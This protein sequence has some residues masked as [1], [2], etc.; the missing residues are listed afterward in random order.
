MTGPSATARRS[1]DPAWTGSQG[2]DVRVP[3]VARIY[4]YLLG[5][6]DN[7]A[8]DRAA[9][10]ELLAAVPDAAVA[11]RANRRFLGRAVWHLARDAG[12]RQFLDIG[13]G[14]PT[15]G[16]VHE[17]AR[18]AGQDARVV[19]CDNDPLVAVHASVAAVHGN[20]RQPRQLLARPA[21][22]AQLNL[23]EPVVVLLVACCTSSRTARTPGRSWRRSSSN[24]HPAVSGDL[25]RHRG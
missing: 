3:N 22:R 9:A 24:W 14:L 18:P 15:R 16:N 1:A 13:T 6:K 11:A 17:I 7:F 19:Y 5:G 8:A 20:L 12:I 23:D 10:G 4:D 25:S 21:L 2:F